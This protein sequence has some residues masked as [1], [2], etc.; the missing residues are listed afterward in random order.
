MDERHKYEAAR[1]PEENVCVSQRDKGENSPNRMLFV[2]QL[3]ATI[4]KGAS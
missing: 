4:D 2:Q 1:L 3:S